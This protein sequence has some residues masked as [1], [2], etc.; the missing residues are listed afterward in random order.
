MIYSDGTKI[1]PL[2]FADARA[3]VYSKRTGLS[4]SVVWEISIHAVM[5]QMSV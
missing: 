1:K 2:L 3:V 4:D 5:L